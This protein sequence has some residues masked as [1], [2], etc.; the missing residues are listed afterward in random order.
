MVK[1]LT[2]DAPWRAILTLSL[3]ML[4]SVAFQQMYSIADSVIAGNWA[5]EFALSEVGASYPITM[6]FLAFATGG[7]AGA[8]V[9]A[10]RLFGAK[11]IRQLKTAVY[12][13]L[14]AFSVLA[15]VLTLSGLILSAPMLQLLG[16]P[17]SIMPN[18]DAYLK[19]YI[20]GLLF[21]FLYNACNG[22]F[23]ALGDSK[24]PLYFLIGSSVGNVV[25]DLIFVLGFDMG[26]SGV[27]WATFIAQ[28]IAAVL[29]VITLLRRIGKIDSE[30]P[31]I[32]SRNMLLQISRISV[33]SILQSS[34]VS[35]GN[36][37]IQSLVNFYGASELGVIG[38]YSAAIKL[39]TFALTCFTTISN[40]ISGFTAQNIGAGRFDR[41]KTG[42]KSGGI[43]SFIIAI[44]FAIAFFFFGGELTSIFATES[45]EGI[46]RTGRIFLQIVSPFYLVIGFKIVIDG[47]MRGL[48]IMKPF[49]TATCL[50]LILRVVFAYILSPS[51]GSDGI[52][53]SWPVGW[54]IA[55][56][57]DVIFYYYYIIKENAV[58]KTI[59]K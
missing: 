59:Y 55:L 7:S 25:L 19:I 23:T 57:V 21:L 54:M 27:A 30:K 5:G 39:N 14:I 40:S 8:S 6:I 45:G 11:E 26:V 53:M 22:I 36:L 3:P 24:T 35:V 41:V 4:I 43:M 56:L 28:G 58:Q 42:I 12:T 9:V 50:D 20:A 29:S 31:Q 46:I 32:F 18:S 16:T 1:D 13:T 15:A 2:K 47:A 33:P 51:F 38:G 17:V 52:W 37:F 44:P 34:F 10:A 48:G 49:V